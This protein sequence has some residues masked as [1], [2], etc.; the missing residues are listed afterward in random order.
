MFLSV[1]CCRHTERCHCS[2]PAY[3]SF[4]SGCWLKGAQLCFTNSA[5]KQQVAH[6]CQIKSNLIRARQNTLQP[7][8]E[9]PNVSAN[10]GLITLL[11]EITGNGLQCALFRFSDAGSVLTLLCDLLLTCF[12]RDIDRNL[13]RVCSLYQSVPT[14]YKVWAQVWLKN[15]SIL[16]KY[17]ICRL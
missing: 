1:P 10:T 9:P 5:E 16:I 11:G 15:V 17:F 2:K 14:K 7:Y 8:L 3:K 13:K 4:T 12:R 6:W